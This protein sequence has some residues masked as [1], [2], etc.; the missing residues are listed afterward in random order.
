MERGKMDTP[1]TQIH[2]NSLSW[3][4][5]GTSIKWQGYT[6]FMGPNFMLCWASDFTCYNLFLLTTQEEKEIKKEEEAAE[7]QKAKGDKKGSSSAKKSENGGSK[8]P[9]PKKGKYLL[10]Y[11]VTNT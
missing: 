5:T 1:D 9:G 4:G 6:S 3:L 10:Y 8:I 11:I 2:E 7:K